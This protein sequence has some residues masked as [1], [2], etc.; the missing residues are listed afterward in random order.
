MSLFFVHVR[1]ILKRVLAL[2]LPLLCAVW[3]SGVVGE[4]TCLSAHKPLRGHDRLTEYKEAGE[5]G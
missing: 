5:A 4:L 1:A 2:P 3:E